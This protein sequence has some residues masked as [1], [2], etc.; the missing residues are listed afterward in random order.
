MIGVMCSFSGELKWFTCSVLLICVFLLDYSTVIH[1][2]KLCRHESPRRGFVETPE[3]MK[4]PCCLPESWKASFIIHSVLG[5]KRISRVDHGV[6]RVRR[7]SNGSVEQ[8][9]LVIGKS[10]SSPEFCHLGLS[11]TS[12]ISRSLCPKDKVYCLHAPFFGEPRCL[13]EANGYKLRS[14]KKTEGIREV[15]QMW[16]ID[17]TNRLHGN[18][19]R[20]IYH[21]SRKYGLCRLLDYHVQWGYYALPWRSCRLFVQKE[22]RYT[23]VPGTFKL[24]FE[25]NITDNL[26]FC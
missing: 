21:V 19:Q 3:L 4:K 7:S 2:D 12:E 6:F 23:P 24:N 5:R 1:A 16:F 13:T 9:L 18:I 26:L 22:Q 17:K 25:H 8:A 15:R 14:S 10:V 11:N 20:Q